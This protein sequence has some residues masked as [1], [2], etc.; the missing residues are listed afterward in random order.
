MISRFSS[1]VL[2][3][4]IIAS[5]SATTPA[6]VHFRGQV[7]PSPA[8]PQQESSPGQ[9][10]TDAGKLELE[11]VKLY[12]EGKYEEALPLARQVLKIREQLLPAN[13]PLVADSLGSLAMLYVA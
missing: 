10:L 1:F 12:K 3:L 13:D 7:Q 9:D 2:V 5:L 11:V 4:L 6:V 8:F